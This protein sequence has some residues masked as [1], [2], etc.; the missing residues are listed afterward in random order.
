MFK[1]YH[2]ILF[3]I[4]CLITIDGHGQCSSMKA[5][6]VPDV[7]KYT[8]LKAYDIQLP[9]RK[10][11]KMRPPTKRYSVMLSKG[12]RYRVTGCVNRSVSF[13]PMVFSLYDNF[14]L[15]TTSYNQNSNKHY[16]AFEFICNKSGI[17]YLTFYFVDGIIGCGA[18]SLAMRKTI[19]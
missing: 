3:F 12:T 2:K 7:S 5:K 14:G 19:K 4:A 17:Y 16:P 18:G 15:V 6:C 1:T 10:N 9:K 13:K 11:R 8:L